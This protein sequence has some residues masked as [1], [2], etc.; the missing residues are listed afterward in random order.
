[1]QPIR[2]DLLE[3]MEGCEAASDHRGAG[4]AGS[5]GQCVE[6]SAAPFTPQTQNSPLALDSKDDGGF[7][8]FETLGRSHFEVG[9]P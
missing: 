5:D 9:L 8:D 1:M 2:M 3:H 4:A 7:T 6:P